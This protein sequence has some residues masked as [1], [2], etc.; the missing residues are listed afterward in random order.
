MLKKK[1]EPLIVILKKAE[2]QYP[3]FEKNLSLNIVIN[4]VIKRNECNLVQLLSRESGLMSLN[5]FQPRISFSQTQG[6]SCLIGH[7][8]QGARSPASQIIS[9]LPII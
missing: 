3:Y 5:G 8:T 4:I 9:C 6:M 1:I 2:P 7:H